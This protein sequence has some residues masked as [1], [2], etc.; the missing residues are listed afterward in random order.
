MIPPQESKIWIASA[1][2]AICILKYAINAAVS[3]SSSAS[4]VARSV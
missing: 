1:P 3:F 4:N 2:A